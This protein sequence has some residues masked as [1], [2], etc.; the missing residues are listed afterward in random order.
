MAAF[1][2]LKIALGYQRKFGD[3]ILLAPFA[4]FGTWLWANIVMGG[5][6]QLALGFAM[7]GELGA[8]YYTFILTRPLLAG[9]FF[10]LAFGNRTEVIVTAPVFLYLLWNRGC[11]PT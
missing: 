3:A 4:C 11:G 7:L 9:C 1:L 10:A 6:W 2:F 5:A 8:I